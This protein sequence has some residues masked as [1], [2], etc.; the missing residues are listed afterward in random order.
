MTHPA[1]LPPEVLWTQVKASRR[2][3]SGPG[4]QH[5]NKT[6]TAMKLL[7]EPTG[8][9]SEATERR[10]LEQNRKVALWR[11][12]LAL[13]LEHREPAVEEPSEL[14]RRRT[15]GG[16]L[17]VSENHEDVPALMAEALDVLADAADDPAAAAE[18]LGVSRSRFLRVLK[19]ERRAF[20]ALNER[21]KARGERGLG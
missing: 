20:A 11:L 13:A 18:R 10:S 2:K 17:A 19:L 14:W 4:G 1:A 5:R 16:K 15:G 3:A 9:F 6:E 7:H 8:V 21:R 12:R